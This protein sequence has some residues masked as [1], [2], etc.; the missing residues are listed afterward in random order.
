MSR[1]AKL[2]SMPGNL[3]LQTV[4]FG[5]LVYTTL[6]HQIWDKPSTWQGGETAEEKRE[7][8][9]STSSRLPSI[10]HL[11]TTLHIKNRAVESPQD[12]QLT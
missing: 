1:K 7:G 5:A 6:Y 2:T 3:W 8:D 12:S 11:L 10:C 4:H 9:V